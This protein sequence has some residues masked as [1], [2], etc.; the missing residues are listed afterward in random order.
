MED[1][2]RL[3]TALYGFDG[4][5]GRRDF[6][7]NAMYITAIAMLI[8]IPFGFWISANITN[9]SDYFDMPK[10]FMQTPIWLKFWIISLGT[11]T[12]TLSISNTFRRL[13]D[14]SGK[15]NMGLNISLAIFFVMNAIGTYL[16]PY[17]L[18]SILGIV[19]FVIS[20]CLYFIPGKI[21]SKYPYDFRKT[22]NWGAFF[23][24]WIWGLINKTYVTL[25]QL[26]LFFTPWGFIFAVICGLKGNEWA[27]KN[28]KCNDVEEFNKSQKK[29]ST[30]FSV[31]TLILVP[32]LYFLFIIAM[33]T[34]FV[35]AASM[36]TQTEPCPLNNSGEQTPAVKIESKLDSFISN[37][38]NLYFEKYTIENNENKF[39]V[40]NSDWKYAGFDQKKEMLDLAAT[41]AANERRNMR[42]SDPK[43]ESEYYSK[44]SELKRTKIYSSETGKL[45][46]EY[47]M[48]ENIE[49]SSSFMDIVKSAV[50][51]YRFY[52]P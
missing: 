8:S 21:T 18:S 13:N 43:A 50:N 40:L 1:K 3:N 9:F 12:L 5:I 16:F 6:A 52:Q 4:I 42:K 27:Y 23:G 22:F 15:V 7:L 39:Y 37:M 20:M 41:V 49:N 10:I 26:I 2:L 31:L 34:M 45:L 14:I 48:D 35:I 44:T 25:W 51:A 36:N 47:V 24:T 46:G 32:V 28:K 29:Q 17:A 11:V 30:I 33:V 19:T 38:A